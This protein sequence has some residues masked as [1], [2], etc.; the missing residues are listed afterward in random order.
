MGRKIDPSMRLSIKGDREE[1]DLEIRKTH[2]IQYFFFWSFIYGLHL[3]LSI[4][5]GEEGNSMHI[6]AVVNVIS[7][8]CVVQLKRKLLSY[9]LS[10]C[11]Q[12]QKNM[13][14]Q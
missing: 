14:C 7:F 1:I 9:N 13:S 5:N 8:Y 2:D 11:L 3:L 12:H 4:A 6:A 10:F